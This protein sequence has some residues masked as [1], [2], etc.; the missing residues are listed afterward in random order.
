M[1]TFFKKMSGMLQEHGPEDTWSS[2]RFAF[3]FSVILANVII[4]VTWAVLSI[5]EGV[6][7]DIPEGVIWMYALATGIT[8][9]G[10][11]IQKFKEMK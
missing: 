10:K 1:G 3:I 7:S 8:F 11:V 5:K 2:T 4:F 9:G 6:M